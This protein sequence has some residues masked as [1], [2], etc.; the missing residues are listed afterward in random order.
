MA[1]PGGSD[2]K[3]ARWPLWVL[4]A[5]IVALIVAMFRIIGMKWWQIP[6]ALAYGVIISMIITVP[7]EIV[8][9]RDKKRKAARDQQVRDDTVLP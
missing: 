5:L 7:A 3:S 9:R 6:L 8:R 4:L 2:Q 1:Q